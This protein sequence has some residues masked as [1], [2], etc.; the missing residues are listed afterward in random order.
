LGMP[1]ENQSIYKLIR[2][3][4]QGIVAGIEEEIA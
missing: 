3:V 1:K 2:V 4:P